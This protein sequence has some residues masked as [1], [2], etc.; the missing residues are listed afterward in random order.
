MLVSG[1]NSGDSVVPKNQHLSV[2]VDASGNLMQIDAID[3]GVSSKVG[4]KMCFYKSMPGNNSEGEFQASGACVF[5]PMDAVQCM[6]AKTF[7]VKKGEKLK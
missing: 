3:A 2:Q 6:G 7:T 5:R 1:E 4:Q